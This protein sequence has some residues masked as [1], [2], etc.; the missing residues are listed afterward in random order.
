MKNTQPSPPIAVHDLELLELIR[1]LERVDFVFDTHS[2]DATKS[3]QAHDGSPMDKLVFRAHALD[4]QGTYLR[5]LQHLHGNKRLVGSVYA[6]LYL[7]FGFV[8]AFG[9][10]IGHWINFFYLLMALLGWHT[11]SLLFWLIRPKTT[12]LFGVAAKFITTLQSKLTPNDT[13]G[14]TALAVIMDKEE[15]IRHWQIASHIHKAWVFALMGNILALFGLFLF[16]SYTFVWESTLLTQAHMAKLIYLIGYIPSLLGFASPSTQ[17][18]ISGDANPAVIAKLIIISLVIYG[19]LPRLLAWGYCLYKIRSYTYTIDKT[20][21]YYENLFRKFNQNIVSPD[22]FC[23]T[24]P[25]KVPTKAIIAQG[26]KIV[27]TLELAEADSWYQFGAGH[28]V[29]NLGA[30][31]EAAD[32]ERLR[33]AIATYEHQVYLGIDSRLLPDR[34]LVR[35]LG[36]IASLARY[37]VIV[38]L[39]HQGEH[40]QAWQQTLIEM[41]L[42]QVYY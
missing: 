3:A 34:G 21:Y 25:I 33:H 20:L 1:R 38:E 23:Q 6:L 30:L 40:Y 22:D 7:I 10:L 2:D 15:P 18:L 4:K 28:N 17:Q 32:F 31:D 27:A 37:G 9:L 19:L 29:I 36:T 12:P 5:T 8:G 24:A 14:K 41:N 11:L 13:L 39:L 42:A 16:K 26:K 35:K